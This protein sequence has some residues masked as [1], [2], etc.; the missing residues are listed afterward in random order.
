MS[1][2]KPERNEIVKA[3]Q[4]HGYNWNSNGDKMING[5]GKSLTFSTSGGSA[6]LNGTSY[7][8]SSGTKKS[9]KW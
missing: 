9:T 1:L 4:A 5:S 7:N 3:A 6:N 2:N 8:T